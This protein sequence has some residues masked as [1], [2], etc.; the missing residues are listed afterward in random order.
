MVVGRRARNFFVA[1]NVLEY[2][3]EMVERRYDWHLAA[4]LSAVRTWFDSVGRIYSITWTSSWGSE[5]GRYCGVPWRKCHCNWFT[6]NVFYLDN[7]V[8]LLALADKFLLDIEILEAFFN[9][10]LGPVAACTVVVLDN[11]GWGDIN[12]VKISG[13]VSKR[14]GIFDA[15]ICDHN[16]WFSGA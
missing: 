4:K 15:F 1:P 7:E 2:W 11:S 14:N 5:S 13:L 9:C 16:F 12:N 10:C 8:L 6:G 3:L